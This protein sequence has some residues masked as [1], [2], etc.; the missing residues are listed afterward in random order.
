MVAM[1]LSKSIASLYIEMSQ[2]INSG[3]VASETG[4][5][6][7]STTPTRFEDFAKNALAIA[8]RAM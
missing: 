8:F 7:A 3:L 4:R 5:T 6:P 1:G 2:G